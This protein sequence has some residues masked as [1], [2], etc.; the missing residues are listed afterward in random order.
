MAD[1][2][3]LVGVGLEKTFKPISVISIGS[4]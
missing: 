1:L 4:I 3:A 2:Q